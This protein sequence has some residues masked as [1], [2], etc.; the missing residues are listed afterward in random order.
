MRGI[1]GFA[2]AVVLASSCTKLNESSGAT[3]DSGGAP[4]AIDAPIPSSAAD[5]SPVSVGNRPAEQAKDGRENSSTDPD[6]HGSAA[7]DGGTPYGAVPYDGAAPPTLVTCDQRPCSPQKDGCCPIACSMANDADCSGVCGNSMLEPG[8]TCDPA[9]T[10]PLSC[11]ARGCSVFRLDGNPAQ[12]D[13]RCVQ[14]G[15]ISVCKDGDGCCPPGCTALND[16]DCQATCGNG[17]KEGSETCDPLT[18]CPLSCPADGCLLKKLVNAGT[19]QAE[20][21]A[22]G[23]QTRCQGGDGC[24]PASCNANNDS[25]CAPKCGNRVQEPGELCDQDCPTSCPPQSCQLRKLEGA[26]TC[27]A[28]CVNDRLQTACISGD[29]CC[30]GGGVCDALRDRDC[31]STCGNGTV[32]PGEVCDGNCPADCPSQGCTRRQLQGSPSQCNVKCVNAGAVTA[33]TSGDGCCPSGCHHDEDNDC[34]QQCSG[35]SVECMNE[36]T[37]RTCVGGTWETTKCAGGGNCFKDAGG[38]G[39]RCGCKIQACTCDVATNS[40]FTPCGI[41]GVPSRAGCI[42]LPPSGGCL[43][44]KGKC[45]NDD[46]HLNDCP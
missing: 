24:C 41:F 26:G 35:S 33:C 31:P 1:S 44:P 5:G 42:S 30:P 12:C 13:S 3:A 32:E 11:P 19:C 28:R 27:N 6:A 2:L 40:T 37:L 10:C 18:T 4:A 43:D 25:D 21:V 20:C 45:V 23:T 38:G 9:G 34:P 39:P 17:V 22:D 15:S 36:S 29:G 7:R 14:S 16:N 8:E 46:P